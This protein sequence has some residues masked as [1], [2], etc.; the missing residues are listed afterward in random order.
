MIG[1]SSTDSTTHYVQGFHNADLHASAQASE[2]LLISVIEV[3]LMSINVHKIKHW[4]VHL[5][6]YRVAYTISVHPLTGP[7]L[8]QCVN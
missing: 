6:L 1:F 3:M 8:M 2:S 7:I 4:P 5:K